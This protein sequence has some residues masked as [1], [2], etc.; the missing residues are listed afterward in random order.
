MTASSLA[1]ANN[2]PVNDHLNDVINDLPGAQIRWYQWWDSH[3]VE[4]AAV[5]HN[6][7]PAHANWLEASQFTIVG[8]LLEGGEA[9][10][11]RA[12]FHHGRDHHPSGQRRRVVRGAASRRQEIQHEVLNAA[13]DDILHFWRSISPLRKSPRVGI[14]PFVG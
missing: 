11:I 14:M 4:A 10:A 6:I 12:E 8:D 7:K 5:K 3:S 2:T 1:C 9:P 13:L